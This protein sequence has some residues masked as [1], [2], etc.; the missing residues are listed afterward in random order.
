MKEVVF[1]DRAHAGRLLGEALAK[2]AGQPDLLILALPRGGVPV[3]HE[4]ARRLQAP[5]DV[6]VVRKVGVPGHEEFAMGAI[7]SGGIQVRESMVLEALG[8]PEEAFA[9][10]AAVQARELR[11]RELAYRGDSTLPVIEG[12]TVILVDDGIATGATIRA[13]AEALRQQRPRRLVIAAPTAA[14]DSCATLAP[15]ADEIVT[16]SRPA[17]FRGVSQWYEDFSQTPDAEVTRLLALHPPQTPWQREGA[18]A[19]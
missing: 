2:Y 6:L 18:M 1:H 16:V 11:R 8:I 13:A 5:L 14:R 4:V 12:K 7:A 9:A 19:G 10:E 15:Q 17:E 3:A